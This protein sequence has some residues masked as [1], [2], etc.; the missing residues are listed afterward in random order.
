MEGKILI[1]QVTKSELLQSIRSAMALQRV[2]VVAVEPR[3]YH[4]TIGFL[5]GLPVKASPGDY[6]GLPLAEPMM[7]LCLP[8]SKL[9]GVLSA[10]RAVGVP[11]MPKAMLTATNAGW[12]PAELLAELRR[13]REAIEKMKKK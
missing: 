11:P 5:A 13:E 9:D 10:L 12:K 7:V 8:Q 6:P 1:F 4:Q 3:Q 2:E